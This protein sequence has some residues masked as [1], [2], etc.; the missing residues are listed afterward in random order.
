MDTRNYSSFTKF[1]RKFELTIT[2]LDQFDKEKNTSVIADEIKY[3]GLGIF[4]S[5][6]DSS[7]K[8]VSIL[9]ESHVFTIEELNA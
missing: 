1:D 3:Y 4:F 6:P 5:I 2:D 7:K 8:I 9:K